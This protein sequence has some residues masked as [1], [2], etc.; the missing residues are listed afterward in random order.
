[1]VCHMIVCAPLTK[2]SD[3]P[4]QQRLYC[5]TC[6]KEKNETSVRQTI[7]NCM[8]QS[9]NS[10]LTNLAELQGKLFSLKEKREQLRQ[11]VQKAH[12]YSV[13]VAECC[14]S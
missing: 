4:T 11:C 1:M 12:K 7:V 9:G 5:D 6:G 13:E 14:T 2:S 10:V 3:M 8:L